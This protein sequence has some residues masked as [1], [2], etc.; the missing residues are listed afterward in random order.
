MLAVAAEEDGTLDPVQG[1]DPAGNPSL[2][3]QQPTLGIRNVQ[4]QFPG[5]RTP[6]L[7]EP[8]TVRFSTLTNLPPFGIV[9]FRD[10]LFL[11]GTLNLGLFGH[12]IEMLQRGLFVDRVE[13]P[14]I[15]DSVIQL[16]PSDQPLPPLV[17]KK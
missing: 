7:A 17:E 16:A 13:K 11:P 14:W 12:E 9:R 6:R 4:I 15:N 2:T 8:V 1:T 5:A 3:I 10:P